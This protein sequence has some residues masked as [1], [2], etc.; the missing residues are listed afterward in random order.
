VDLPP[1]TYVVL[2]DFAHHPRDGYFNLLRYLQDH[3][4]CVEVI[5]NA[6]IIKTDLDHEGLLESIKR[7]TDH[8]DF[9]V[10]AKLAEFVGGLGGDLG[11]ARELREQI[12]A[13]RPI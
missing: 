3:E 5:S 1:N 10:V 4:H 11:R 7:R 6:W 12:I 8:A 13:L 9:V 2:I